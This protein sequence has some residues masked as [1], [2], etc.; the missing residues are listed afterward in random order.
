MD[1]YHSKKQTYLDDKIPFQESEISC[2]RDPGM[3]QPEARWPSLAIYH[4][5]E[6]VAVLIKLVNAGPEVIA[7]KSAYTGLE[8]V[9]NPTVLT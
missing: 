4:E 5:S 6:L 7:C 9:S 8:P 2:T 1:C 3:L